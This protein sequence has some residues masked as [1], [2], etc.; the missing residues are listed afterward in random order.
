MLP[1]F[2]LQKY[3]V[4]LEGITA[5]PEWSP[6]PVEHTDAPE[7]EPVP[8]SVPPKPFR[9]SRVFDYVDE[10]AIEVRHTFFEI[11]KVNFIGFFFVSACTM[12][13]CVCLQQVSMEEH[14]RFKDLIWHLI[15]ARDI[16]NELE[17]A[18]AIFLWLCTKVSEAGI[19]IKTGL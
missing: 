17:K 14:P 11:T 5:P 7:P 9:D 3:S 15:Y 6:R 12:Y 2:Y 16:S 4:S 19:L 13:L 10:H 1:L 18:R 8:A